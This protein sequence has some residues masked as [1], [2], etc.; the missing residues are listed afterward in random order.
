MNA[1]RH[2]APRTLIVWSSRGALLLFDLDVLQ[3]I[4]QNERT[5]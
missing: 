5:L 2:A 1:R 4:Y 3:P